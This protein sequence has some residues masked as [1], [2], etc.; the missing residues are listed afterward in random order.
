LLPE[1][2]KYDGREGLLK[3]QAEEASRAAAAGVS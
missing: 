3:K 1:F 2:L